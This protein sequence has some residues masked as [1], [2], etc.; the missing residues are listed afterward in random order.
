MWSQI[1]SIFKLSKSF[2]Y[3]LTFSLSHIEISNIILSMIMQQQGICIQ[4]ESTSIDPLVKWSN[5]NIRMNINLSP[6]VLI[7]TK[8]NSDKLFI[9]KRF[10]TYIKEIFY[11]RQWK[12][13]KLSNHKWHKNHFWQM[14][15]KINKKRNR[16]DLSLFFNQTFNIW[17]IVF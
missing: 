14:Q 2:I 3:F 4:T 11:S 13:I 7:R 15:E 17:E 9:N 10:A 16:S 5:Q 1:K 6:W 8:L 12:Y